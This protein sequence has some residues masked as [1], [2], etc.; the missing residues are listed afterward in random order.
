MKRLK[1]QSVS[2]RDFAIQS[3]ELERELKLTRE[4]KEE[5]MQLAR[6][7]GG[8]RTDD[9]EAEIARIERELQSLRERAELTQR[10]RAANRARRGGAG[11]FRPSYGD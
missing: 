1:R 8:D 9:F 5:W 10:K 7:I 2:P 3:R 11:P 4:T 6:G